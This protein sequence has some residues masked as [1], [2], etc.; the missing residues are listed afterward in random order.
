MTEKIYRKVVMTLEGVITSK[1]DKVIQLLSE[2]YSMRHHY[3]DVKIYWDKQKEMYVVKVEVEHVRSSNFDKCLVESLLQE[4]IQ[5]T[6][7]VVPHTQYQ[8]LNVELLE[9]QEKKL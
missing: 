9:F 6:T 1:T 3:K 8:I 5:V 4:L 2:E 7:A